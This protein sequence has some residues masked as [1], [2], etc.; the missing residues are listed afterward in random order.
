MPNLVGTL[1]R[2][3]LYEKVLISD[4]EKAFLTVRI[5]KSDRDAC[6]IL[7]LKDHHKPPTP[8]NILVL[9][10]CAVL[11]GLICSPY[12]LAATIRHHLKNYPDMQVDLKEELLRNLYVD[13]ACV[14][15]ATTEEVLAKYNSLKEAFNAA[16]MNLRDF[17]SNDQQAMAE[18]PE[19]DRGKNLSPKFMGIRWHSQTD[20]I[21]VPSIEKPD[22]KNK[23]TKRRVV[24]YLNSQYDPLGWRVPDLLPM[25]MY[26][27]K[28]C[29]ASFNWDDELP[30]HYLDELNEIHSKIA[31]HG[32]RI[33]RSI[34]NAE[35]L[36]KPHQLI[37]FT[38][39]SNQALGTCVY[40]RC[41]ELRK[42][43]L[44]FAKSALADPEMTIP[45][46]K[47]KI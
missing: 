46:K 3:R 20:N 4:I 19:V 21:E 5:D 30:K 29:E 43:H 25:K 16:S 1:L 40:L 39:A 22:F 6:R 38:D 44:L 14:G 36:K 41:P 32:A 7:W 18:I 35:D 26:Y 24:Q 17:I 15:A 45:K 11:F 8:D 42:A 33:N 34:S 2:F 28:I 31:S 37:V 9:R 27:R 12:L 10:F 23:W 13:N 47:R